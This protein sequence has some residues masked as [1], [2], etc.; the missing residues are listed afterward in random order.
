MSE[1]DNPHE[2]LEVFREAISSA[3]DS[4]IYILISGQEEGYFQIDPF[5]LGVSDQT[6]ADL[7]PQQRDV[8]KK[9]LYN[10]SGIID[11]KLQAFDTY[12]TGEDGNLTVRI[13]E[14]TGLD[15]EGDVHIFYVHE[16]QHEDGALDWQLSNSFNRLL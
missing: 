15:D 2:E 9:E 1:S 7:T 4:T 13:I 8:L 14:G 10:Q 3:I 11:G 16:I 6:N 12:R 5:S